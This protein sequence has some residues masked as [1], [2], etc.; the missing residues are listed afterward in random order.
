M[1][2]RKLGATAAWAAFAVTGI[3]LAANA[4]AASTPA[5]GAGSLDFWF[6]APIANATVS[7]ILSPGSTC[8]VNATGSVSK[9]TFSLDS[10]VLNA[11]STPSDGMQCSLDTTKF[12]NGAHALKAV[13]TDS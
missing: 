1:N 4:N 6:K 2:V 13:A 8:Y 5:P 9:V 10:T 12:P 3:T 11:D 7:G